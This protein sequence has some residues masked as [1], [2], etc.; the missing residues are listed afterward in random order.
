MIDFHLLTIFPIFTVHAMNKLY[1]SGSLG[2]SNIF[3]AKQENQFLL[4]NYRFDFQFLTIIPLFAVHAAAMNKR[5]Y[6]QKK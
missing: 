3:Q 4:T 5:L 2:L 6:K 1:I